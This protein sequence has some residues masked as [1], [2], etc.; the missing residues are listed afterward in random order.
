L[1]NATEQS[2]SR[3]WGSLKVKIRYVF[4]SLCL[5]LALGMASTP[6]TARPEGSCPPAGE[7]LESVFSIWGDSGHWALILQG[8]GTCTDGTLTTAKALPYLVW[9]GGGHPPERVSVSFQVQDMT[10][11]QGTVGMGPSKVV[12][13][14]DCKLIAPGQGVLAPQST[15]ELVRAIATNGRFE[16]A[17]DRKAEQISWR[18]A[19]PPARN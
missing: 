5:M 4:L 6:V 9:T 18:Y 19:Y 2:E 11:V 17:W 12:R 16:V 8:L 7:S 14:A 3:E 1:G 10:C 13:I 15:V